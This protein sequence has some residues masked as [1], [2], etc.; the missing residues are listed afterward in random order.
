VLRIV[1]ILLETFWGSLLLF[2]LALHFRIT[3]YCLDFFLILRICFQLLLVYR[4]KMYRSE[5]QQSKICLQG[6]AQHLTF[7]ATWSFQRL[8]RPCSIYGES[9][10]M[11][12]FATASHHPYT[13]DH[14]F[15]SSINGLLWMQATIPVA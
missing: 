11:L 8:H 3:Y 7:C 10:L 2:H 14:I 5:D 15:G 6:V 12:G 9:Q 1:T 4:S 13:S